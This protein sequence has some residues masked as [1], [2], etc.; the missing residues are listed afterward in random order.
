[1]KET[2]IQFLTFSIAIAAW[3]IS[4]IQLK[5]T[6]RQNNEDII[7]NQ[8]LECYRKIIKESYEFLVITTKLLDEVSDFNGTKEQWDQEFMPLKFKIH[9][10]EIEQL[11]A[12]RKEYSILLPEHILIE[13][14][15]FV[16]CCYRFIVDYCNLDNE[17]C[18]DIFNKLTES[19][20]KFINYTRQDLHIEV[21]NKKLNYRLRD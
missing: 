7:F 17:K 9:H 15:R 2:S 8:K 5:R 11:D 20:H 18:I 12:F 6:R 4:Y 16:F 19:H 13:F 14:D 21:L 10:P 1:M 3:L